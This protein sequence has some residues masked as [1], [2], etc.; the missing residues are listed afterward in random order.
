MNFHYLKI[1]GEADED[2]IFYQ[3]ATLFDKKFYSGPYIGESFKN[4]NLY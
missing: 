1:E 4:S 3:L 2:I